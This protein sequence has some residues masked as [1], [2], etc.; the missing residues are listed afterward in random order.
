[1]S[2][3][4][5]DGFAGQRFLTLPV[6]TVERLEADTLTRLL[7][8]YAIGFFPRAEYHYVSRSQGCGE[9]ILL[10][11][12]EGSG[13]VD[14]G[15]SSMRLNANQFVVIP[16]GAPHTYFCDANHP[17]SIYWM[18]IRG[19]LSAQLLQGMDA[20]RDVPPS[21]SSRIDERNRLFDEIFQ[22]LDS[23]VSTEAYEYASALLVHYL[24]TFRHLGIYRT[25][26][27]AASSVSQGDTAVRRV[28][29]FMNENIE[30]RLTVDDLAACCGLSASYLYRR[31]VKEVGMAPMDYFIRLKVNRACFWLMRTNMTVSQISSRLD[32]SES[33][34]FAR[35]FKKVMGV[36]ATDY[37][38][39]CVSTD[40]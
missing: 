39:S 21:D 17:W 29:H 27:P 30:R 3:K 4:I 20:P 34:Y 15:S 18:H 13:T 24:A 26:N 32:F 25:S 23:N 19:E 1:M 10:Y 37:R 6:Q 8:V 33:Q 38:A 40:A 36:S 5:A 9:H 7:Y 12:T 16:R 2:I 11:C 28:L 35:T 14:V 22:T 31:F